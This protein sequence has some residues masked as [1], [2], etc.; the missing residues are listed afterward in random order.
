MQI[1]CSSRKQEALLGMPDIN[2][3]NII[4]IN[5][6]TVDMQESDRANHCTTKHEHHTNILQEADRAKK[7]A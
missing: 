7:Y 3:L 1:I 4:H 2:T 5:C 6:N